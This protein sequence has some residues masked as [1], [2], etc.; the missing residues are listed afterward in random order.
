MEDKRLKL[1]AAIFIAVLIAIT[2]YIT[3]AYLIR[4]WPFEKKPETVGDLLKGAGSKDGSL[5]GLFP[6]GKGVYGKSDGNL[7]LF[8]GFS[9]T[10][11]KD[12]LYAEIESMTTGIDPLTPAISVSVRTMAGE[13]LGGGDMTLKDV[14]EQLSKSDKSFKLLESRYVDFLGKQCLLM[15]GQSK[16]GNDEVGLVT[17]IVP[18]KDAFQLVMGT[19][20]LGDEDGKKTVEDVI[21][22]YRPLDVK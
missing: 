4:A 5:E 6:G 14:G 8:K 10:F 1:T 21:A 15:S 16:R 17:F 2:A 11:P 12:W 22:T 20:K 7:K 18:T 9:I 13:E 19:F 3:T